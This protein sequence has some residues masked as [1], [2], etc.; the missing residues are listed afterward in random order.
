[1]HYIGVGCHITTLDF[2]GNEKGRLVQASPVAT[3]VSGLTEFVK[4]AV[5]TLHFPSG[6]SLLEGRRGCERSLPSFEPERGQVVGCSNPVTP[7][8]NQL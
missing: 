3:S 2:I 4:M 1:V 7:T 5:L 6:L 8:L